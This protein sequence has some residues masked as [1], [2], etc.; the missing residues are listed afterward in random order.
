MTGAVVAA[1]VG[2]VHAATWRPPRGARA[3]G[4][5]ARGHGGGSGG[6]GGGRSRGRAGRGR[7]RVASGV[8]AGEQPDT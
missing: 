8:P 7:G 6:R 1:S 5:G 4:G 3:R 2:A